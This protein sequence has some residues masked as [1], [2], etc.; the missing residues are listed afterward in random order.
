M[1]NKTLLAESYIKYIL[2]VVLKLRP[3]DALS[4]NTEGNLLEVAL[5][6]AQEASEITFK[7]VNV[8]PL[9]GGAVSESIPIKPLMNPIDTSHPE[10][11]VMLRLDDTE[12]C[13]WE[14]EEEAKVV[15][16]SAPL[17]QAVGN[18]APPQLDREVAPWAV[19][20]YPSARWAT[21]L[22][23]KEEEL[24]SLFKELFNLN[25][26]GYD[27]ERQALVGDLLGH[28][29]RLDGE[30]YSFKGRESDFRVAINPNSHWRSGLCHL[31]DGRPFI[32]LLPLGRLS[33]LTN[34]DTLSGTIATSHPFPLLGSVVEGASFT[35]FE[36]ELIS[37]SAQRGEELLDIA[38]QID[39]GARRVSEISLIDKRLA[40]P[41]KAKGWGYKGFDQAVTHTFTL[42][43]GEA[44]H[45][46][47][48][49]EYTNEEELA[50]ETG[51]NL[52]A[53]RVRVPFDLESLSV[54]CEGE[55]TIMRDGEFIF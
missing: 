54:T 30:L 48:L 18:L 9:E 13:Y 52:S 49:G 43:M 26:E 1:E 50:Q 14:I 6:M 31:S 11:P 10:R 25:Q 8:V 2:E 51:C 36:G 33:M 21:Y 35:F 12:G 37:Y 17:L 34:C 41:P 27:S 38:L 53:I 20:P 40:L 24:W 23:M 46:E 39:M 45:I 55:G 28:L 22:S 47:A 29:N 32:S 44:S 19:I 4:I 3:F 7:E 16:E 15:A 5:D 42:G